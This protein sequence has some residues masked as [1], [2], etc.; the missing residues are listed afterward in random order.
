MGRVWLGNAG[1]MQGAI[2]TTR[3]QHRTTLVA[4]LRAHT[5]QQT[6]E[7]ISLFD[8]YPRVPKQVTVPV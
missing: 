7:N 6:V 2:Y 4:L 3:T 8:R 5:V 1:E